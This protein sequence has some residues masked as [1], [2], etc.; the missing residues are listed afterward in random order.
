MHSQISL[1]LLR[2]QRRVG[3]V[4]LI[5]KSLEAS[6]V[7]GLGAVVLGVLDLYIGLVLRIL[8]LL[9]RVRRP[10]L[11]GRLVLRRSGAGL[12]V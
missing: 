8:S 12:P 11:G 7:R 10:G 3:P 9:L 1:I 2:V 5:V 4:A 6:A